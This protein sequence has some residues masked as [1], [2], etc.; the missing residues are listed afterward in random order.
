MK[1]LLYGVLAVASLA[2][3]L[4]A[5]SRDFLNAD[6]I[7]LIRE[8]QE[9]NDRLKLYTTFA[10]ERMDLVKNL[11]SKDKPGR[12]LMIHD[13]LEDYA[14]IL[15]AIDSVADAAAAKHTDIRQGLTVVAT[16]GK[17]IMPELKKIQ[18]SVPKDLERY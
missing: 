11:L 5:Q 2:I 1:T 13:A 3:P 8:A 12:S 14:K 7:E 17:M 10:K 18:A 6:E 9:P 16:T 4:G 15:D